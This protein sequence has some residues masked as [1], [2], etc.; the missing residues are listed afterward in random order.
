VMHQDDRYLPEV[1]QVIDLI[2]D[3]LKERCRSIDPSQ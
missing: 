2:F 3:I 1:R